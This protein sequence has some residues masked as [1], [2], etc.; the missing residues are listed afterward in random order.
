MGYRDD[1]YKVENLIGY[2][3][4]LNDF[5]TAYFQDG[6]DYG[7][8]TQRHDMPTNVG[9]QAVETDSD[10]EIG[11][12]LVDGEAKLVEFNSE[13]AFHVSRSTLTEWD[14]MS[15]GDQSILAK[16]ITNCP[17]EKYI[18]GY[19]D[20]VFDDLDDT[21]LHMGRLIQQINVRVKRG[22]FR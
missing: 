22:T 4:N 10:Y 2:S 7:H 1:F 21:E 16:A 5:P 17:N 12:Y 20:E 18:S 14:D 13:G 8:I 6:D 9:R 19:S 15:S 3:G 11:N